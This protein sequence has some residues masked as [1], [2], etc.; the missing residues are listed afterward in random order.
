MKR[1]TLQLKSGDRLQY[2][3]SISLRYGKAEIEGV[4]LQHDDI[5]LPHWKEFVDALQQYS[6]EPEK[7]HDRVLHMHNVQLPPSVSDMLTPILQLK[8]FT[9]DVEGYWN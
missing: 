3:E 2:D 6:H 8:G 5:F 4:T 1:A 9:L 7:R